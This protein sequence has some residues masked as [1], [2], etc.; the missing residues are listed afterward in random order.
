MICGLPGYKVSAAGF[1]FDAGVIMMLAQCLACFKFRSARYLRATVTLLLAKL[2]H[3]DESRG[4]KDHG[5]DSKARG[6]DSKARGADS[7]ARGS[8]SKAR[9]KGT[10][11][12]MIYG[13]LSCRKQ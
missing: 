8:D 13:L 12:R 9:D 7:K 2:L 11:K 5:S 1:R 3:V 4:P 6:A 10:P